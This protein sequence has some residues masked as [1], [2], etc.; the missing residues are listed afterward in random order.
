MRP[1]E[2]ILLV[3]ALLAT[4]ACTVP[5]PHRRPDAGPDS[6]AGT[7]PIACTSACTGDTGVC[8]TS[9]GQCVQ[10]TAADHAACSGN[11]PACGTGGTCQACTQ[12]SQCDS[13]VC[14]LDG[15]CGD[16]ANVAYVDPRGGGES[17]TREAPCASFAK[18]LTTDRLY[19]KTTSVVKENVTINRGKPVIIFADPKAQ[20]TADSGTLLQVLGGSDVTI[21]D[22]EFTG[23]P[24]TIGFSLQGQTAKVSLDG[25]KFSNHGSGIS[26]SATGSLNANRLVLNGNGYG[27]RVSQA[28]PVTIKNSTVTGNDIGINSVAAGELVVI[29]DSTITDNRNGVELTGGAVKVD[30]STISGNATGILAQAKNRL[31]VFRSMITKNT[32]GGINMVDPTEYS[33]VSNFIVRNGGPS[34]AVGGIKVRPLASLATY[35]EYN[36]IADNVAGSQALSG[37]ASCTADTGA[38]ANARAWYNLYYRNSGGAGVAQMVGNCAVSQ[39][40]NADGATAASPGFANPDTPPN[41]DYH[42]TASSPEP[43]IRNIDNLAFGRPLDFDGQARPRGGGI[44]VGA[45][46]Y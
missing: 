28:A 11:T 46:E 5:N 26:V 35:V 2:R 44:D 33:I 39:S 6:D 22:L 30:R 37:G 13:G 12:H 10:C 17:C 9:V 21:Y 38:E 41:Y 4:A 43:A 15:T 42:I 32:L 20:L 24:Q 23:R 18:A 27:L 29:E 40:F 25:V 36:T 7:E 14:L 34:A 1:V 45:D 8:D 16:S 31:F 3:A 19:I